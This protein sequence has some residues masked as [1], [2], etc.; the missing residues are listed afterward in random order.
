MKEFVLNQCMWDIFKSF[1]LS[2]V[3][4]QKCILPTRAKKK[5][6]SDLMAKEIQSQ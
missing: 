6:K 5:K 2:G 1:T 3:E 4:V